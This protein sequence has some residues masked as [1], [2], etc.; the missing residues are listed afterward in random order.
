[1]DHLSPKPGRFILHRNERQWE[2][3][4]DAPGAT[5]SVITRR[6]SPFFGQIQESKIIIV[7]GIQSGIA[8][9][10]RRLAT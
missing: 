1:V 9:R 6:V 5:F 4:M 7:S 10:L 8:T 3:F 2:L